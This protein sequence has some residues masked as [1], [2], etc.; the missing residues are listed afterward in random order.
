M[1]VNLFVVILVV[2]V[3][4][5]IGFIYFWKINE[6]FRDVVKNIWKNI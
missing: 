4:L 2:V 5:V 6:G 1:L 3:G